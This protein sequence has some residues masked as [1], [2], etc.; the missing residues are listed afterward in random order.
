MIKPFKTTL[1]I[2]FALSLLLLTAADCGGPTPPEDPDPPYDGP[3]EKVEVPD[4]LGNYALDFLGPNDGWVCGYN[5]VGYWDGNGWSVIKE[6]DYAGYYYGLNDI[7]VVAKD[8]IWLCGAKV[9]GNQ[10]YPGVFI[11]YD[12]N[13]WNIDEILGL[14]TALGLWMFDD[15]TGWGGGIWCLL[16]RRERLERNR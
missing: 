11:H 7:F 2:L 1:Q 6:F 8:D 14:D 16:L 13:S 3:W 9:S 4:D 12:G 5:N 10:V 15:G